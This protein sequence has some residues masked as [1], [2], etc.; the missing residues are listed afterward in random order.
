MIRYAILIVALILTASLAMWASVPAPAPEA[1]SAEMVAVAGGTFVMGNTLDGGLDNEKPVHQVTLASYWIGKYEVT[2]P[3]WVR[4]RDWARANGYEFENE[5]Q[6]G[7]GSQTVNTT[8]QANSVDEDAVAAAAATRP[9]FTEQPV[10]NINWYDMVKW[11]N[12][13]SEMQ[14]RTPCYYT[15]SAF[16]TVYKTG[17]KDLLIVMVNW[18]ANGY[19]LPTEAEWEYAAKGGAA[20]VANPFK[21]AGSNEP[22]SVAWYT[23]TSGNATHPVGTRKPNQ[24]GIHDMSGNVWEWCFDW[25]GS[26]TAAA[27]NAPRG[28]ESGQYRVLRGGSCF[29]SDF[30]RSAYR[31]GYVEPAFLNVFGFRLVRGAP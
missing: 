30:L 7:Y 2:Y 12:A 24:L 15:G 5:G 8:P 11:C 29:D 19:R 31:N 28:P 16:R 17:R 3:L 26:Y 27:Q 6:D 10:V 14:G 21:Y 9:S 23:G 13:Y 25:Y 1:G 18:A 22:D 4:V 20:G